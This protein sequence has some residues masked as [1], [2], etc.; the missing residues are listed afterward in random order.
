MEDKVCVD[1]RP[2]DGHRSVALATGRP[3]ER[4]RVRH[5]NGR[6]IPPEILSFAVDRG[7]WDPSI[8]GERPGAEP[9]GRRASRCLDGGRRRVTYLTTID[10]DR[11]CDAVE[12]PHLEIDAG[13]LRK[14]HV[15]V[16]TTVNPY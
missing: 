2:I 10:L 4:N 15:V 12:A 5:A 1:L 13:R 3:R 9:H 14:M 11:V 8:G 7:C 6:T 16:E